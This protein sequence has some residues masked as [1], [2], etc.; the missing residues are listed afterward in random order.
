[1]MVIRPITSKRAM[2]LVMRHHY[3]GRKV[4]VRHAFGLFDSGLLS[5]VVVYSTPASYTL[6]R[7]VCGPDMSK[8]VLE[9]SRLV[10]TTDKKNAASV[11]VG[12]SMRQ[13]GEHI[14]VSYAD[15][16]DHVGHVG[17][18]YQATNWLY[19]GQGTSEPKWV[20]PK[21]GEVISYTRRW[22]DKKAA[23]LGLDWRDLVKVKQQGKHRYVTF[24][25]NRRF[26]RKCRSLLNYKVFPYPKGD[27]TRHN[28][29]RDDTRLFK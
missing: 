5:G 14:L 7:G 24:T 1:M 9:L 4:G 11:L 21:T 17:Y 23:K 3:S 10:V 19:T 12:S 13:L 15:C 20:H 26:K 25:G 22:I 27:T 28:I 29:D 18:I 6:C 2:Y 8:S 16:N